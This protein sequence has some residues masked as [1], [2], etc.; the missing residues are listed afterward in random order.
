MT[1]VIAIAGFIVVA[2]VGWCIAEG[3][4]KFVNYQNNEQ[5]EAVLE[6]NRQALEQNGYTELNI[7]DVSRTIATTG[8][9]AV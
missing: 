2:L 5:E 7:K 8:Y 4:A 3:K 9:S 6:Q 1:T